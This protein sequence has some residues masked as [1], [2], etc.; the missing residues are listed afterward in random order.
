MSG[1]WVHSS[2]QTLVQQNVFLCYEKVNL[3][4]SESNRTKGNNDR[5]YWEETDEM[6]GTAADQM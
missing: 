1:L 2:R 3:L 6:L 5:T 4:L